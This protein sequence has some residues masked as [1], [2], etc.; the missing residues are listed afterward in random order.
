MVGETSILSAAGWR[1]LELVPHVTYAEGWFGSFLLARD[2]VPRS[3]R[4][5]Y[6]GRGR[7]LA[8]PGLGIEVDPQ[9]LMSLS[10]RNPLVYNF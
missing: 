10:D 3:L 7:N 2:V 5:G 4:F 1:F 8:G 9:R 6:G